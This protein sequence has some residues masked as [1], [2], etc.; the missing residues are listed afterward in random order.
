MLRMLPLLIVLILS[1]CSPAV[2]QHSFIEKT[3][4]HPS[5]PRIATQRE[6]TWQVYNMKTL[7]A[8]I[9]ELEAKG[10]A[11]PLIALSP[12]EYTDLM[13]NLNELLRHIQ[14]KD[15]L[16]RHYRSQNIEK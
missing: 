13:M 8:K 16:L 6:V 1:G 14:Q 12:N 3:T 9:A 2:F 10:E 5:L 4:F 15:T 11:F 7:K